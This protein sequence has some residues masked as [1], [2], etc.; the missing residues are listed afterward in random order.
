[1]SRF[2]HIFAGLPV[3]AVEAKLR[4]EAKR[5]RASARF[6]ERVM[7]DQFDKAAGEAFARHYGL[8]AP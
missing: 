6:A 8:I 7:A 2:T 1:M 4:N 3:L 5:L